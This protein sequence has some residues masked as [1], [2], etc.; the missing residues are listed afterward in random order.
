MLKLII[1]KSKSE[2]K[3]SQSED[4]FNQIQIQKQFLKILHRPYKN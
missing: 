4:I 3:D 2:Y 1:V